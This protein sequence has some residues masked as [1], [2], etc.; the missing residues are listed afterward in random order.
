MLMVKIN[1]LRVSI[2]EILRLKYNI[3]KQLGSLIITELF[4]LLGIS[5]NRV[6]C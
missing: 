2:L 1:S 6:E 5:E 3:K 4:F